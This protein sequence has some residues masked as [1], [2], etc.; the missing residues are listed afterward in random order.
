MTDGPDRNARDLGFC[1]ITTHQRRGQ[2]TVGE[3]GDRGWFEL[4]E[5]NAPPPALAACCPRNHA[6]DVDAALCAEQGL[7]SEVAC[8]CPCSARHIVTPDRDPALSSV[9]ANWSCLPRA[10]R[11]RA[12]SSAETCMEQLTEMLGSARRDLAHLIFGLSYWPAAFGT[13]HRLGCPHAIELSETIQEAAKECGNISTV[14][15]AGYLVSDQV[16][17]LRPQPG[18]PIPGFEHFLSA[19]TRPRCEVSELQPELSLPAPPSKAAPSRHVTFALS[20]QFRSQLD[21]HLENN[22][23]KSPSPSD[24]L[25]PSS[26]QRGAITTPISSHCK[27][28]RGRRH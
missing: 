22:P 23:S 19:K 17:L 13:P 9:F 24:P 1:D 25:D 12:P 26:R 3:G 14:L 7:G 11:G 4:W 27:Q 8:G 5:V 21:P 18:V 28:W 10:G 16:F 6:C 20:C 2:P 15:T